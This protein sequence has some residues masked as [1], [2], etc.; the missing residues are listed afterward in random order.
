[1]MIISKHFIKLSVTYC[2]SLLLLISCQGQQEFPT[3]TPAVDI[4]NT[5]SEPSVTEDSFYS[6]PTEL[7]GLEEISREE[8]LNAI[9]RNGVWQEEYIEE[10]NGIDEGAMR[11]RTS[12]YR[13]ISAQE[14]YILREGCV[15][16][17]Y[18][19]LNRREHFEPYVSSSICRYRGDDPVESKYFASTET[20]Q[21][22]KEAY[23]GAE[24]VVSATQTLLSEDLTR[25][26]AAYA[27]LYPFSEIVIADH[28]C[29]NMEIASQWRNTQEAEVDTVTVLILN[30]YWLSNLSA[31]VRV[32][33][34]T[35]SP[36]VGTYEIVEE[37]S[38]SAENE[39]KLYISEQYIYPPQFRVSDSKKQVKSGT[40]EI[41][42]FSYEEIRF[43]FDIEGE[44]NPIKNSA[45]VG[46]NLF[47]RRKTF[48]AYY[49]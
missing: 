25:A 6:I 36:Q 35:D 43:H 34:N 47:Y 23:C 45:I 13:I 41:Y 40:L 24:R 33:L 21:Y 12:T 1:M 22:R 37:F 46:G 26:P 9:V 16:F 30:A 3:N 38:E 15:S 49:D 28:G 5:A 29:M 8:Y 20:G 18:R 2:C 42:D 19:V 44:S 17:N 10:G 39:I 7:T 27:V 4:E 32:E 31:G 48:G 14:N 11:Y